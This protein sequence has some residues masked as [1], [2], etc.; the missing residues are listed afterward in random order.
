M[1]LPG[2]GRSISSTGI[3]NFLQIKSTSEEVRNAWLA[4]PVRARCRIGRDRLELCRGAK[5][6]VCRYRYPGKQSA[7]G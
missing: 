5:A 1:Y 6:M 2:V 4:T 3:V 7:H